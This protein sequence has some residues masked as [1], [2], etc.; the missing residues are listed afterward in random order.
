VAVAEVPH[1]L[2]EPQVAR[3]ADRPR[4]KPEVRPLDSDLARAVVAICQ[5][6]GLRATG[7]VADPYLGPV[8]RTH[9]TRLTAERI[10][11]DREDLRR[12]GPEAVRMAPADLHVVDAPFGEPSRV[13]ELVAEARGKSL[14]RVRPGVGVDAEP[15][16]Q[17]VHVIGDGPDPVRELRRVGDEVAMGVALAGLPPVVNDDV[18]VAGLAHPGCD[19]RLVGLADQGLVDLRA[20]PI[21]A[22]PAHRG[23][24]RQPVV[25]LPQSPGPGSLW[26]PPAPRS[27]DAFQWSGCV[28][29]SASSQ[30]SPSWRSSPRRRPPGRAGPRRSRPPGHR[31]RRPACRRSA[32]E[33]PLLGPCRPASRASTP[34]G[35]GSPAIRRSA[36]AI[37]RPRSSP[38]TTRAPAAG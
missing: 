15:Q 26:R 19:D 38:T 29:P 30:R 10:L 27:P 23:R 31:E 33:S 5:R 12:A 17:R 16:V 7:E 1:V 22:V 2:T 24:R 36:P 9:A 3:S 35:T 4:R 14:T 32:P 8:A 18:A 11:I 37:S 28:S 20:E 21:P 6:D 34:R 13:T 25:G